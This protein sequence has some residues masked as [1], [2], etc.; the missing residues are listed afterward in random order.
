M[1]GRFGSLLAGL[2]TVGAD[3]PLRAESVG[4]GGWT[5]RNWIGFFLYLFVFLLAVI[6]LYRM[7]VADDGG[8]RAAGEGAPPGGPDAAKDGKQA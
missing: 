8:D 3:A 5:P 7:A 2:L 6:G 4:P 1:N